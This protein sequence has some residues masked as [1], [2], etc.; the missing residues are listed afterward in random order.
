MA[1]TMGIDG[2][3]DF[4]RNLKKIDSE[5]PKALRVALNAAA[6]LV[7]DGARPKVPTRSGA[8]RAS[9]KA[10]STR[11]EVRVAAGSKRAPYFPFLDFGGRVGRKKSVKRPFLKDGRY[12]YPT[13]HALK[14]SG[15]FEATLNRAL[16]SVARRA[17]IEV[18]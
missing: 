16:V 4:S 15:E 8:A 17:G 10:K 18:T 1:Y 3:A 6:E 13:Y 9:L 2:L 7:I 12:L 14:Q 5:L 11:T